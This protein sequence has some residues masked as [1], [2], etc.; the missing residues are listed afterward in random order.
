MWLYVSCGFLSVVAHRDDANALLVRARHPDH[1]VSLFPDA[2]VTYMPTADYPYRVTLPRAEVQFAVNLYL[3]QMMYDNVGEVLSIGILL[4]V[5]RVHTVEGDI[6][7]LK[8]PR[9]GAN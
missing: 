1:I 8:V 9:V 5:E 7:H 3:S 2:N 6:A 4:L